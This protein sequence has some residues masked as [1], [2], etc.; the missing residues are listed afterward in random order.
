M[1]VIIMIWVF[2]ILLGVGLSGTVEYLEDDEL[3]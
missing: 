1:D 3:L 2:M